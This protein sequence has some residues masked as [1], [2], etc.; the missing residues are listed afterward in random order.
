M[1]LIIGII[2]TLAND[3]DGPPMLH[4]NEVTALRVMD[5][6]CRMEGSRIQQHLKDYEMRV[7]GYFDDDTLTVEGSSSDAAAAMGLKPVPYTLITGL[8]WLASQPKE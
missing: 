5:D 7:L 6:L 2:D 3:M 1:R 4:K 8:Q